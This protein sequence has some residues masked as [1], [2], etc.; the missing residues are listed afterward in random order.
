V[1]SWCF[2]DIIGMALVVVKVVW[3]WFADKGR[4]RSGFRRISVYKNGIIDL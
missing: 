1:V 4:C 2:G 3:W